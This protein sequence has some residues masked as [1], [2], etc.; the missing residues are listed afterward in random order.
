M[1]SPSLREPDVAVTDE[2]GMPFDEALGTLI[3]EAERE[4]VPVEVPRDVDAVES[5]VWTVE[6]SKVEFDRD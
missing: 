2:E 6:I 5:G 4:G 3:R 1:S